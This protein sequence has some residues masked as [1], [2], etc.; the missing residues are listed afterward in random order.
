MAI[1]KSQKIHPSNG[2]IIKYKGVIDVDS[3][4][5]DVK[6]WF[7]RNSYNYYEKESIEK[8]KSQ[9]NSVIIKMFGIKDVDDYVEFRIDVLFDEILRVKKIDE[10]Y[11]GDARIIIRAEMTFDYK[12]NWK[13]YP[14]LFHIYNNYILKKKINVY[15]WSKIYEDMMDVNSLIKSKLGLIE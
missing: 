13:S 8:T 15:Y 4:Y 11:M 10:G 7:G 9:G 6:S 5:K 12:N 3:L 14:F 2:I 1:G